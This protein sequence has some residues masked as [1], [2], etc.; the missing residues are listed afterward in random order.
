M[1]AA[2][3]DMYRFSFADDPDAVSKSFGQR[4]EL[5]GYSYLSMVQNMGSGFVWLMLS[6]IYQLLFFLVYRIFKAFQM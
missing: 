4:F 2:D 6:A 3:Q 5:Y 1:N